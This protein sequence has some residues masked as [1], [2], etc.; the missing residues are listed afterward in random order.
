MRRLKCSSL[1]RSIGRWGPSAL[2]QT[3]A[4]VGTTILGRPSSFPDG[5]E[6]KHAHASPL[7]K[8]GLTVLGQPIESLN[9]SGLNRSIGRWGPLALPKFRFC[10]FQRGALGDASLPKL[11]TLKRHSDIRTFLLSHIWNPFASR[12]CAPTRVGAA[13]AG[14]NP[15]S[16]IALS[17][18]PPFRPWRPL[19]E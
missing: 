17:L 16:K 6:R 12:V 1:N 5:K 4:P 7:H 11:P 3:T 15:K 13:T 14:K 9:R 10:I 2:P 8:V 18:L 19:R